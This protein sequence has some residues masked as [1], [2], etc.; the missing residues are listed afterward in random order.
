MNTNAIR[1]FAG[2]AAASILACL[3]LPAQAQYQERTIRLS[4]GVGKAHPIGTGVAAMAQCALEKSGG[5][6]KIQGYFDNT[7][8][9]D[10]TATQQVR[11]GSLEMVITSTAP[12]IGSIPQLAI[13]D[14]PFL[15]NNEKEA[16]QIVDGKIG[17]SFT[18]KFA[19]AN[20]VNLAYWEN[21]FRQVTNSKRPITKL[22][23]LPGIKMRVM[24]NKVFIDTF[25]TLGTNA[26]PMAFSELYSGLE[27][28]TVDGQENPIMLIENMKF[29]EVQKYL[30][31]TRHA[32]SPAVALYSKRLFD[33]LSPDEQN[34]LRECAIKGRDVNRTQ[35]REL[36]S[37]TLT[38]LKG[39]GMQINEVSP[40]ELQRMRDKV[41]LVFD[42]QA[43]AVG[44]E[45]M[46]ALV[47]ELKR[48]RG[49]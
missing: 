42:A 43:K 11:T 33:Q 16:D 23:D 22:E 47:A 2:V 25:A 7:L 45:T 35:G 20:L 15:F 5:K 8:G 31:L 13:F 37:K 14:L 46:S 41:Q 12:L 44:E 32:Y 18:P 39:T 17:D 9:N 30:S 36:E 3:T 1:T 21:G 28:R 38:A 34:T 40:Q 27:T 4:N 48:I 6:M 49:K 24:Q 26:V 19:A 10:T 29:Y